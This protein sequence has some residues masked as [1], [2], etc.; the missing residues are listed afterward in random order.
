MRL[1]EKVKIKAPLQKVEDFLL[2]LDQNYKNFH[3]IDH[4]YF[5]FIKRTPKLVGSEF[6]FAEH[7]GGKKICMKARIIEY[8]EHKKVV[9]EAMP[10]ILRIRGGFEIEKFKDYIEV[11]QWDE[12]NTPK[13]LEFLLNIFGFNADMQKFSEHLKE[14]MQFMKKF[15]EKK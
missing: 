2:N 10:S 4:I 1:E 9:W 11:T 14:E 7:I 15:L 12:F 13:W 8:T 5:R 3:P 6:I